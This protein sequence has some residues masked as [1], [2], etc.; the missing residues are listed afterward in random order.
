MTNALAT[1]MAEF[2]SVPVI[3]E[4]PPRRSFH[5]FSFNGFISAVK[6]LR[7]HR[8]NPQ[9]RSAENAYNEALKSHSI[10]MFADAESSYLRCLDL[11][12]DHEPAHVN[13]ASLLIQRNSI[14]LAL[15]HLE[16]AVHYRP[17]Y[18]RAYYN[19]ALLYKQLEHYEE[20]RT[21]FTESLLRKPDHFWSHLGMAE[22]YLHQGRFEEALDC[23]KEALNHTRR[24]QAV[25][26]RLAELYFLSES[27]DEA[28]HFT[29]KAL[30]SGR[31]P[32]LLY[33]LA[34]LMASRGKNLREAVGLFVEASR[35]RK[36]F[37]DAWQNISLCYSSLNEQEECMK[38][39]E[40]FFHMTA[41]IDPETKIE[42][43]RKLLI[44]NAQNSLV[45][46]AIAKLLFDQGRPAA[47]LD[48]IQVLL[49][50]APG[51]IPALE[52][53]G[54]Y[55]LKMGRHKDAIGAFRK[56]VERAP[57][58][59]SGYLGLVEAYGAVENYAAAM[60]VVRKA[61][62]FEPRNPKIHYMLGTLLAQEGDLE[63]ALM[64]YSTVNSLDPHFPRI[65]KRMRMLDD[66][67]KARKEEEEITG[68]WPTLEPRRT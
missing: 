14:E 26:E 39:A 60:P 18:F 67:I 68:P 63:R 33:N 10:G 65:R 55:C 34:R 54:D 32:E 29:R 3:F 37:A 59:P 36:D 4:A 23:Y 30:D 27:F 9:Y 17:A 35:H 1:H 62:E 45:R 5:I 6:Y 20:A 8:K 66:E 57:D 49:S 50:H 15:E 25:Y 22:L 56:L 19:L 53:L 47:A 58:S 38:A 12:P 24:P 31:K 43:L 41:K 28:E 46:L 64:H 21:M 42:F 11:Q 48:E 2:H 16:K 52:A 51:H 44:V 13:L 40:R 7:H 61:L